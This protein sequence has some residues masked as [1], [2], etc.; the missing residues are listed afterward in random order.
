MSVES[1]LIPRKGYL[2]VIIAAMM[3]AVSGASGKFLFNQGVTPLQVVQLRVTLSAVFIFLF[4]L[5]RRPALLKVSR[6]DIIYFAVLGVTGMAMVMFTYFYTISKI[7]VAVAILLQYLAPVYI[8]IYYV[9]IAPE[10]LTRLTLV[11]I[12]LSVLGCYLA[13]GAYNF[14][15]LALKWEGIV[16]GI[17]AGLFYAWYAVYSERGM[18]RYDPWTVVFYALLFAALFWNIALPP[19]EAFRVPYS[20]VEWFWIFYIVLFGTAVPFSLYTM[21]ISLIRSTRASVTATLEPIAAGFIAYIFLGEL[22]EPLQI[23]GGAAVIASVILLQTRREYDETTSTIMRKKGEHDRNT[24]TW[25]QP[26]D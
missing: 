16:A 23:L 17:C 7:N 13:V 9:F 15:L 20:S 11:A 25:I 6:G 18:C 3:W 5:V 8:A 19:L 1:G 26:L 12:A 22:L 10:K 4:L 21:G 24:S 2:L 14:N